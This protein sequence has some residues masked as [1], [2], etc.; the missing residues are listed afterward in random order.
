M[1][2]VEAGTEFTIRSQK[3]GSHGSLTHVPP[4]QE[5]S[6]RDDGAPRTSGEKIEPGT[7]WDY[8]FT[9]AVPGNHMCHCHVN[10]ALH[11]D[12][13]MYGVLRV[14]PSEGS[15]RGHGRQPDREYF[16]TFREWD[17]RVSDFH[18]RLLPEKYTAS[19]GGTDV[20]SDGGGHGNHTISGD[21][22]LDPSDRDPDLF[23]FNGR[24]APTT[25][26]E[27]NGYPVIVEEGNLVRLHFADTGFE[28]HS[29]HTLTPVRPHRTAGGV[30]RRRPEH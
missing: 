12:M 19:G 26:F 22:T 9:A 5:R 29:M 11:T 1:I 4:A 20:D 21:G 10:T 13:G 8:E 18:T 24:A 6:W 25:F 7:E 23:S 15:S 30:S 3:R 2:R 16:Y 27:E 28:S 14:D 17:S